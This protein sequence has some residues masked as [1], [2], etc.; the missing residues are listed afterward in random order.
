MKVK[1]P[2]GVDSEV[3][4]YEVSINDDLAKLLINLMRYFIEFVS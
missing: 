4:A 2:I 1:T 3:Y